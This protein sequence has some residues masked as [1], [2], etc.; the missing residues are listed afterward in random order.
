MPYALFITLSTFIYP[1][2]LCPLFLYASG[3]T[4]CFIISR[5]IDIKKLVDTRRGKV[6]ENWKGD[7][8]EEQ[9]MVGE[10]GMVWG[11]E[12]IL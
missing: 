1:Y 2:N 6:I 7:G 10:G 4:Q 9:E 5:V 11:R 8:L 12:G 3:K